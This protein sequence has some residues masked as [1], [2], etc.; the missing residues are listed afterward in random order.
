MTNMICK[1][2]GSTSLIADRAL[3]GRLVC[4]RCGGQAVKAPSKLYSRKISNTL[5]NKKTVL[6][7]ICIFIVIFLVVGI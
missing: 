5:A 6:F 7:I 2:C 3:A 1:R 4:A